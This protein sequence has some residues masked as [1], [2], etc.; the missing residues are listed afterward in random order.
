MVFAD[1]IILPKQIGFIIGNNEHK[2]VFCVKMKQ[3]I[4]LS[5][6]EK[7]K[8]RLALSDTERFRAAMAMLRLKKKL[9]KAVITKP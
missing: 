9:Q 4:I 3:P 8:N 7:I 5:E 6:E 2:F 1:F